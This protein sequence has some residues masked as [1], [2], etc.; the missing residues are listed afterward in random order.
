MLE[1]IDIPSS[2]DKPPTLR[3]WF[4]TPT[5]LDLNRSES[6]SVAGLSFTSTWPCGPL[7]F[8]SSEFP[9]PIDEKKNLEREGVARTGWS[10]WLDVAMGTK[11]E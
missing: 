5:T 3:S 4:A 9:C 7:Y 2:N 8:E 10:E 11:A 6:T 1:H